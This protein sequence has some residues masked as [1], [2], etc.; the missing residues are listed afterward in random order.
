MADYLSAFFFF[1][2]G[3]VSGSLLA[4]IDAGVAFCP[5]SSWTVTVYPTSNFCSSL[6][7]MPGYSVLVL[8]VTFT[9]YVAPVTF[10]VLGACTVIVLPS[11]LMDLMV[12]ATTPP[13]VTS[14]GAFFFCLA[15]A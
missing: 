2:F 8:S 5:A 13:A 12:P 10:L 3:G 6:L 14:V 15:S 7:S 9:S 4:L 1:F 11:S